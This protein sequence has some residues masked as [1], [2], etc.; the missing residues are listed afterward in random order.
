MRTTLSFEEQS[1]VNQKV[2]ESGLTGLKAL[3][4]AQRYSWE[5]LSNANQPFD[6]EL[7]AQERFCN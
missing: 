3:E 5:M 7:D 1:Y 6:F 2:T 4:L